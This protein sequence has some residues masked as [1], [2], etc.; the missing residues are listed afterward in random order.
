MNFVSWTLAWEWLFYF[1]AFLLFKFAKYFDIKYFY[2]IFILILISLFI[3][4]FNKK[5]ETYRFIGFYLGCLI[6]LLHFN[7]KNKYL[8]IIS[9]VSILAQIF[10]FGYFN[11][12][13]ISSDFKLLYYIVFDIMVS[14]FLITLLCQETFLKVIFKSKLLVFLGK[15]SYS[16]YL[17]HA[18]IGIYFST[19]FL[20]NYHF[21]Y[22]INAVIT[23]IF[24]VIIAAIFFL[25]TERPYFIYKSAKKNAN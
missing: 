23:F 24:S 17:T 19:I 16:F 12:Y 4:M 8:Q 25:I 2:V 20:K 14:I 9:L 6:F 22:F 13:M 5:L 1:I 11:Q 7:L 18:M 3:Y 15:I 21:N 10:M